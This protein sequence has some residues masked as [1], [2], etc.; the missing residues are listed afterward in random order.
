MDTLATTGRKNA[1]DTNVGKKPALLSAE[2][3][4]L[5]YGGKTIVDQLS[6]EIPA[7]QITAIIGPNGCGKSTLLAGL[8][9]L[10][11]PKAGRV[12]LNGRCIHQQQGRSVARQLALLPQQ[13]LAPDGLTVAELVRFGRQPHQGMLQRW[14]DTDA[15]HVEQAME[16]TRVSALAG[17]P[18]DEVSGGQRQRAWLAMVVAQDT[19]LLLLDEPTSALDLGHQLEVFEVIRQLVRQGKTIVMVVHDIIAACR[20]ADHM[21]AM[22]NGQVLA[23]GT[24]DAIV[25]EQL[26]QQLYGVNCQIMRDP[27]NGSLLLAGVNRTGHVL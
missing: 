7:G 5:G 10:M 1:L 9:R 15:R 2:N 14:S 6:L 22:K 27:V 24:P 12:L 13:M 20:Y 26:M 8:A 18:L 25:T 11:K 4:V 23:S 21:I 19:P 17:Q 16:L 3:L